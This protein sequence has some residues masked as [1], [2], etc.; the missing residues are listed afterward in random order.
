MRQMITRCPHCGVTLRK[1]KTPVVCSA[2]AWPSGEFRQAQ[3][4]QVQAA[5]HLRLGGG[6][7]DVRKRVA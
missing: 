4:S 7:L 2:R 1:F 5:S 6:G 3:G